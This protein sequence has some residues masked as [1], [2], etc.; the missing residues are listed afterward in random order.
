MYFVDHQIRVCGGV[1]FF[2]SAILKGPRLVVL[3][4][5]RKFLRDKREREVSDDSEAKR[6]VASCVRN[7]WGLY[8]QWKRLIKTR[9]Y[10]HGAFRQAVSQRSWITT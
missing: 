7:S 3:Q 8:L 9:I 4:D 10:S 2:W 6:D 5:W 1:K